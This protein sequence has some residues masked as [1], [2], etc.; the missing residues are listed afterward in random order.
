MTGESVPLAVDI[1]SGQL[2]TGWV[3]S[4]GA[5]NADKLTNLGDVII[6]PDGLWCIR[7]SRSLYGICHSNYQ[8]VIYMAWSIRL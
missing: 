3:N 7:W 4:G 5:S 6:R 8:L 1:W 2:A